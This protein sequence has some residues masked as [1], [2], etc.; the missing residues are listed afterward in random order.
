[1]K[2][3]EQVG[4]LSVPNPYHCATD[5]SSLD[6]DIWSTLHPPALSLR[7]N[8]LMRKQSMNI[9][10]KIRRELTSS[11]RSFTSFQM[12]HTHASLLRGFFVATARLVAK[13]LSGPWSGIQRLTQDQNTGK[14]SAIELPGWLRATSSRSFQISI[15]YV[16]Q[17]LHL[18][19]LLR[20]VASGLRQMASTVS[21]ICCRED[22]GRIRTQVISWILKLLEDRQVGLSVIVENVPKNR[23]QLVDLTRCRCGS[24][25]GG[26]GVC[27]FHLGSRQ[28]FMAFFPLV[29]TVGLL[30]KVMP[31]PVLV[32]F[33]D[34]EVPTPVIGELGGLF[35][36]VYPS[37][38][39]STDVTDDAIEEELRLA[40][41]VYPIPVYFRHHEARGPLGS[42]VIVPLWRY[43]HGAGDVVVQSP[44]GGD[45][46]LHVLEGWDF[47]G[48]QG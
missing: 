4:G 13:L 37:I 1:M 36:R 31:I 38:L 33:G 20:Q 47:D 21:Q 5:A 7:W 19:S 11:G 42:E 3:I 27:V 44:F 34:I 43:G 48:P 30:R 41:P 46:L 23:G 28:G 6:G 16:W 29:R 8:K 22:L 25:I 26:D 14:K 32:H 12:V 10:K 40:V 45:R 9:G 18:L 17:L 39:V 24:G 2:K 35:P 15:A